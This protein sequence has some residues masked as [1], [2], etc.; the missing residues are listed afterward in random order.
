M[1]PTYPPPFG[2]GGLLESSCL[3][4]LDACRAEHTRR[5]PR[6]GTSWISQRCDHV[7]VRPLIRSRTHDASHTPRAP[8]LARFCPL[9]PVCPVSASEWDTSQTAECT[10][11]PPPRAAC[12]ARTAS[13]APEYGSDA[14]D[15]Y[16]WVVIQFGYVSLF[17]MVFPP[18]A[19]IALIIGCVQLR[20]DAFKV[21]ANAITCP[22]CQPSSI[23]H[24]ISIS[25]GTKRVEL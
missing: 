14:F 1:S 25:P 13:P 18:T 17:S 16:A 12:N 8:Q 5:N 19:F 7:T 23:R 21:K 15:D 20:M 6:F 22:S 24:G 2:L 10:R 4:W 11:P 9:V 3:G